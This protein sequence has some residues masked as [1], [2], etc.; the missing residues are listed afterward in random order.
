M[1]ERALKYIVYISIGIMM[2]L[3]G[4]TGCNRLVNADSS[5]LYST[6]DL[7]KRYR[8]I[9]HNQQAATARLLVGISLTEALV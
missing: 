8:E 4:I 2:I 3:A 9:V 1:E 7:N 6:N 5:V